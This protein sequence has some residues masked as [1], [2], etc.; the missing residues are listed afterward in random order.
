LHVR[1][2]PGRPSIFPILAV[3]FVGTLGFSIVLPSLVFLV[4]RFGGNALVYGLVGATYSFFQLIGA[5]ILGRWSDRY[6]RRRMLLASVLGTCASWAIFLVAIEIPDHPLANVDS[7]LLGTFTLTV[8]LA[9]LFLARA[10]AGL[11][12]GDVSIANAYL[13]DISDEH[14]RSEHF[15][16]MA[17]SSNLGFVA[18]PALAGSF[19]AMGMGE[20]LPVVAALV[21]SAFSALAHRVPPRRNACVLASDPEKV[22][23]RSR[24]ARSRKSA[25]AC[26]P[27]RSRR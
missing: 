9:T 13:A 23:V 3:N 17:M 14:N 2:E 16:R 22:N 19:G 5:P 21:I 27:A 18:G 7:A 24:S 4:T 20:L 12:G 6:G 26:A 11:T 8:P 10:L 1:P 15:G 25:S